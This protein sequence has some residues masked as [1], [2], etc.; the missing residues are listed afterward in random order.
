MTTKLTLSEYEANKKFEDD[1]EIN[2]AGIKIEKDKIQICLK[3]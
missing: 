3:I 1:A 2:P